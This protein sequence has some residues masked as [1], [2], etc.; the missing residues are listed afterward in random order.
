[1]FHDKDGLLWIRLT[2]YNYPWTAL[3][4]PSQYQKEALCKAHNS[5]FANLKTYIKIMS[6]YYWPGIYQ[7]GKKHVQ[8]CLTCKQ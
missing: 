3:L 7:D 8:T 5:I 1:M 4:L 6:S 2:D